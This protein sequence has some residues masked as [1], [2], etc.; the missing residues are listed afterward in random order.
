MSSRSE[1][2]FEQTQRG[3]VTE[4]T[5]SRA[6]SIARTS[7]ASRL[8]VS[9][10]AWSM[11]EAWNGMRDFSSIL[12]HDVL[13]GQA[14]I[15]FGEFLRRDLEAGQRQKLGL[16]A[17]GDDL[18]IDEHAVAIEDDKVGG[19]HGNPGMRGGPAAQGRSSGAAYTKRGAAANRRLLAVS[20]F[21]V[22]F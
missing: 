17:R 3:P 6:P 18:G 12:Q 14:G 22:C 20:H 16:D 10:S 13:E 1:L 7:L 2:E 5:A 9:A 15:A 8:S 4:A 21:V 11:S 19:G